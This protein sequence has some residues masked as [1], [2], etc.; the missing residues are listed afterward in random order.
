MGIYVIKHIP[1]QEILPL[2]F[3]NEV[4]AKSE[5]DM[6]ITLFKTKLTDAELLHEHLLFYSKKVFAETLFAKFNIYPNIEDFSIVF[7]EESKVTKKLKLMLHKKLET[8]F[9]P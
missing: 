9:I 5:L 7:Y 1:S 2:L 3:G 6:L 8:L 4:E